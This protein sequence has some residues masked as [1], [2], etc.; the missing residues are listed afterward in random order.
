MSF[1]D[2]SEETKLVINNLIDKHWPNL[3][4]GGRG[5]VCNNVAKTILSPEYRKNPREFI[6]AN[7]KMM[8]TDPD[9]NSMSAVSFKIICKLQ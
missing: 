1:S 3:T 9:E 8:M 5:A 6:S 2:L 7:R 4:P